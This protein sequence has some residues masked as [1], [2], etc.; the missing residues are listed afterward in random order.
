MSTLERALRHGDLLLLVVG[1][2]IGS[3]IFLVPGV[4]LQ[5][6]KGY[7][8]LALAIWV[9]G[10]L[11]SLLGALTYGELSIRRPQAGGLYVYLREAFG[12]LVAFLYGWALLLAI[13]SG[14]LA[15]L[16]VAFG[17]YLDHLFPVSL[18]GQKVA[19]IGLIAWVTAVNI[20]GVRYGAW[21]QNGTTILKIGALLALSALLL[22]GSELSGLHREPVRWWPDS[23]DMTWLGGAG[24]GLIGV[25]WAYEG[26]QYGTFSA[27]EVRN[28]QRAFP[29]AFSLGL[30]ILIVLY[31]LVN[32]AYVAALG[33]ERMAG[34]V[35]VAAEAVS[36]VWGP[37][38]GRWVALAILLSILGAANGLV[39]TA[40]RVYYAM[41]RDGL[42]FSWL[43]GVHARYRTPVPA[44]LFG[45]G[46][47]ILLALAGTFEELLTYVV[48]S[49]WIFYGLGAMSLLHYRRRDPGSAGYQ[50]PGYPWTPLVFALAALTIVG[51]TFVV[52]PLQAGMGLLIVATGVPV[53]A[54]WRRRAARRAEDLAEDG[55]R[56]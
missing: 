4:V 5:Q 51:N 56:R 39:L 37:E 22:I 6:A 50:T 17:E 34:S 25:L 1:L 29:L 9:V 41:A 54:F 12:P 19:A 21:V 52:R 10:G 3:G 18:A 13:A 26:W 43:G 35:S 15:T 14:A 53:Y 45:S 46:W 33:V 28:P 31:G 27:G 36:H 40:S 44:L 38:A 11:L 32:M 42:L 8:G 20:R 47:A 16:A 23:R 48:F 55:A 49:G 7:V 2:V 30:V 24:L